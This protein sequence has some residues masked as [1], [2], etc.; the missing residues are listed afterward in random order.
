MNRVIA[1]GAASALMV[2]SCAQDCCAL[3]EHGRNGDLNL[4]GA[5]RA[6]DRE[7]WCAT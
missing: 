2:F 1:L 5:L 7:I 4:S 3:A 6:K